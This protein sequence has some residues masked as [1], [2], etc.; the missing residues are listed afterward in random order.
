MSEG[1][2]KGN[3]KEAAAAAGSSSSAKKVDTL[4]P[5]SKVKTIMK[6]S[7]EVEHIGVETLYLVTKATVSFFIIFLLGFLRCSD[8]VFY[9]LKELF[10]EHLAKQ[11]YQSAKGNKALGY[12][13]LSDYI[14]KTDSMAFLRGEDFCLM[15]LLCVMSY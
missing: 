11:S 9:L 6:S 8:S 2:S 5:Q 13:N 10:V 15:N 14:H 1:K 4:L 3:N 7:P 12:K